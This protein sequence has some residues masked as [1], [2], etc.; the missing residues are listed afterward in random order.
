MVQKIEMG[1]TDLS[2]PGAEFLSFRKSQQGLFGA[3]AVAKVGALDLT[4]IA[5]QQEGETATQTFVGQARQDSTSVQDWQYVKRKYYWVEHPALLTESEPDSVG[6]LPL[7]NFTL[8]LDDF[9]TRN[10]NELGARQ[11]FAFV[12]PTTGSTTDSVGVAPGFYHELEENVDYAI[13]FDSGTLTLNGFLGR[14]HKLAAI[15]T[16][17]DGRQQGD[18]SNPDTLRLRLLSPT[19]TDLYDEAKGFTE[20]QILEQKNVYNIGA[21]NVNKESFELTI[22]RRQNQAGQQ[23]EDNQEGVEFVKVLGLD[24][25]GVSDLEPDLLVEPEFISSEEGVIRFPNILPFAPDSSLFDLDGTGEVAVNVIV[26]PDQVSTGR[27]RGEKEGPVLTDQNAVI[28]T[29]A[30][31]LITNQGKYVI[32]MKFS[33]PTPTFSLNRFNIIEGSETV[34]LN[35]RI[36]NQ[37]TDYTIDYDFGQLTFLTEEAGQADASI[38]VDFEFVPLFGQAKESLLGASGTYNFSPDT[39]LSSSWLFFSRSTPEERPKLGQEPSR[40]LVGNLYGQWVTNPGFMTGLVNSLPLV[41][42]ETE[43]EFQVQGETAMSIPNPNTKNEVYIDD[44]EGVEDSRDLAITRGLWVP[45]SEPVGPTMELDKELVDPLPL[46]WYNPDNVVRRR[47][48]FTEQAEE[49]EGQDFIQVLEMRAKNASVPGDTGWFGVMRNLSRNGEDFSEK[50]FLE[51]WVNDFGQY[52]PASFGGQGEGGGKLIFDMG[53]ISEDFYVNSA[54]P[55]KGRGIFDTEDADFDGELTSS[56]EDFGLDFVQGIDGTNVPNDDGTDD[57]D[58]TRSD[59]DSIK[60]ERI[61]GWEGN[62]RLDTED[63]DG[64]RV[65]S[66][67]NNY[68]SYVIDLSNVEVG[69][70]GGPVIFNN[71]FEPGNYWRLYRILLD[72]GEL[73]GGIPRR[74]AIKYARLWADGIDSA[75]GAKLQIASI[76]ILGSTWRERQQAFLDDGS[77]VE[78]GFEDGAF[79]V[80][81]LNNKE[82]AIYCEP[83]D[84]GEE[85]NEP[86]RE[87][88]LT[89]IYEDIPSGA[90]ADSADVG[91]PRRAGARGQ[92]LSRHSGSR[93]GREPGLH[94]VRGHELLPARRRVRRLRVPSS[95]TRAIGGNVLLPLRPGH[96]ELLR[97]FHRR[98]PRRRRGVYLARGGPQS[99][100]PRGAETGAA[101]RHPLRGRSAGGV[102][103]PCGQQRHAR[104][105]RSAHAESGA[106]AHARYPR[107]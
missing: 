67:D 25:K 26:S 47:D 71:E 11:G 61:N 68:L 36:L 101:G 102:P 86:R 2:L 30:P 94:P 89:M 14:D 59:P 105:V 77:P 88:S 72:D 54:N 35:G 84:P 65:L 19:E 21:L 75:P 6:V 44:M 27:S 8:F 29:D 64:D 32:E 93:P 39:R 38:E 3:K 92:R 55:V 48:V 79:A 73:V 74:R 76:K 10:D 43:S 23:D 66:T 82:S 45:A 37:G 87:Q 107:G 7:R 49:Q 16:W 96:H 4:V 106:P 20:V 90:R 58:F 95:R 9:D 33:T 24:Y 40:I 13:D 22:K 103:L 12:D 41:R 28:Y 52:V 83:F 34:R 1:N 62:S 15:Y 97:V 100:R 31:D 104:R 81:V 60:Y 98:H 63:L 70:P 85:G 17:D 50:K 46:A 42:T 78:E 91:L 69:S 18:A 99:Q 53:A 57:F 5:S 56:T 80:N 51:I